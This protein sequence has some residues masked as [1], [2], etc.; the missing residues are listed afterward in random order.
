MQVLRWLNRRCK[1]EISLISPTIR[2]TAAARLK[3]ALF[4]QRF[5]KLPLQGCNQPYFANN[6]PKR[7]CKAEISLISPTT[8]QTAAARL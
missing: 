1:A 8:H 7:R 2:H 3:S 4:R 6:S 5:A